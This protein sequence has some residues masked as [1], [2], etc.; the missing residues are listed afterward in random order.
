M[1]LTSTHKVFVCVGIQVIHSLFLTHN[2]YELA[3]RSCDLSVMLL[4]V[5]P[6]G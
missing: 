5:S 1:Q 2:L 6:G 3:H 4:S